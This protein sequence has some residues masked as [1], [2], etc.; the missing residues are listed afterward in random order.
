[1]CCVKEL[2]EMQA[3]AVTAR[4]SDTAVG[5][6]TD[7]FAFNVSEITDGI[8]TPLFTRASSMT[9]A[10]QQP[11]F[12]NPGDSAGVKKRRGRPR[13]GIQEAS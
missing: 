3:E 2:R 5:A 6:A 12:V 8:E 10:S 11:K 7:N 1:V 13:T 9:P 4:S